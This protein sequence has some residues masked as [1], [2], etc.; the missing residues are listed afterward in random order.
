MQINA[1]THI[2]YVSLSVHLT[3][4][5]NSPI[6]MKY[7]HYDIG[8]RGIGDLNR[9]TYATLTTFFWTFINPYKDLHQLTWFFF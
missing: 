8:C 9:D 7:K 2:F 3:W 4:E 5:Y 6:Y 1:H